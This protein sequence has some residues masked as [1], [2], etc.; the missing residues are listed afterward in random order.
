VG[1]GDAEPSL[2]GQERC[3]E[4]PVG[5]RRQGD[6][7]SERESHAARAQREFHL[8]ALHMG[9]QKMLDRPDY[10]DCKHVEDEQAVADPPQVDQYRWMFCF[11]LTVG[12]RQNASRSQ[13]DAG[14]KQNAP[15]A[16]I[17]RRA[18]DEYQQRR[19][20]QAGDQDRRPQ[21][22]ARTPSFLP[23]EH[24]TQRAQGDRVQTREGVRPNCRVRQA[25]V[26]N[27]DAS[28]GRQTQAAEG[29]GHHSTRWK[30]SNERGPH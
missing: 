4:V 22:L 5:E 20:R 17:D 27:G 29:K 19:H 9:H 2:E 6:R 3:L 16:M 30:K 28:H 24:G 15:G 12:A 13:G 25:Q 1:F 21:A 26:E 8:P 23:H 18:Q 14:I 10:L 11:V 7:Q